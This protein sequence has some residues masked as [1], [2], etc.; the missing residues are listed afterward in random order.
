MVEHAFATG[1]RRK[2]VLYWGTR[3]LADMY[4]RELCER[5]A[6]EHPSFT[7]VPVLSEPRPEDHWTG[8]TGLVHEAILA[9]F[10][11][12]AGHQV[13]ACGSVAMVEAA[14]PAFRAR[15]MDPNDCFSD[16]FRLS[17][18]LARATAAEELVRLGGA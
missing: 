14:H 1:L 15:G 5:W 17:P 4:A 12:L 18:H 10:P 11:T 2:M 16:A 3:T 6:R 7:F 13:Y 9:D 8:R